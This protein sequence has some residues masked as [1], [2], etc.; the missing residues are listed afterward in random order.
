MEAVS[1]DS[2]Q[3]EEFVAEGES[4]IGGRVEEEGLL[5][6]QQLRGHCSIIEIM[7]ILGV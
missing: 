5:E 2:P 3:A 7:T 4:W 6:L 1:V